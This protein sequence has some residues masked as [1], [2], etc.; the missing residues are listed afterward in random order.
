[1]VNDK[2]RVSSDTRNHHTSSSTKT[3][4]SSTVKT[5]DPLSVQFSRF[6]ATIEALLEQCH[7]KLEESKQFC[8][9]LT[10]TISDNSNDEHLF[11][12]E[13]LQKINACTTFKELFVILRKHWS[14]RAYSILTHIIS[15]TGLKEA[16]D[17]VDLFETRMASYQG[18]KIIS[19]EISPEAIPPDYIRLS[20]LI[21]KP[22]R[23]LT[24]EKYAEL[25][26]F[27]FRN[28]DTKHYT[29]LPYIKFLFGSLQLE[30]YVLKKAAPYMIKMAQQN[31]EIFMSNSVVFIQ[32]DQHVVLDCRA[33][34]KTQIVS[35]KNSILF[36]G[37]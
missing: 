1:M 21:T 6:V 31:E 28:L 7:D 27:V 24:V 3:A 23:D 20:V 33:K 32:I 11:N 26:D 35:P 18:M 30:W 14:W 2:H 9:N 34:D 13:Q 36:D 16:Q 15:I 10:Y 4:A 37:A 17:E 8:M 25:H 29:A 12:D 22:Y 19:E 5:P